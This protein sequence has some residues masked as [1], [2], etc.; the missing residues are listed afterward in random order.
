[1]AN[2]S[3]RLRAADSRMVTLLGVMLATTCLSNQVLAQSAPNGSNKAAPAE[4][5]DII[6]TAQRRETELTD[7]PIA[8]SAIGAEEIARRHIVDLNDLQLSVP[9]LVFVQ[10]TRQEAFI[11]I[12]GTSV[13]NDKP[14]SDPGVSVFVDGV[15]RTGVH[16]NNPDLFDLQ[17]AE[18]LRGPQGTLFGRNTTG[19]A[20]LLRTTDPSF[21]PEV[22]AQLTYGSDNLVDANALVTG[23]VVGDTLAGKVAF[24]YHRR[25]PNVY[26]VTQARYN[27]AEK[28]YSVRG[29]L[30][31]QPI[32]DLKILMRADYLRD[33]SESRVGHLEGTFAPVLFPGLQFGPDITN[34]LFT[35]HAT[36]TIL[37]L[38]ATVDWALDAG[39]ITSI[40]GYRAVTPNIDYTPTGDPFAE[41]LGAQRIRDHQL[42]Q[43][44]HFASKAGGRLTYL[45]GLFYLHLNRADDTLFTL[46]ALPGTALSYTPG[47]TPGFQ[48]HPNEEVLT[49]SR[50]AFGELTY[51]LLSDL[52]FTLGARYS[53]ESRSGHTENE[54]FASSGPYSHTWN[55]FTPK[56][57]ISFRPASHVLIY[58]TV[59]KGFQSGGFDAAA[60]TPGGLR[61]PFSPETV[62]NYELGLKIKAF[63]NRL[64]GNLALFWA[65]Y[66]NLQRTEFDSDPMV[67]AYKTTN[68]GKARVKGVELDIRYKPL[69]WLELG[70]SYAYTD[71][72][73]RAYLLLQDDGSFIDYS[74]NTVPQ[75]PK[76]QVHL[77][78]ELN[79]PLRSTGGML[80]FGADYT[81]RS[82]IQFVDANDTPTSILD[83][84]QYNGVINIHAGWQAVSGR[85]S[86][87]LFAKNVT[88][89][90]A[91]V[92]FPDFTPYFANLPEFRNP[93]NHIF[94]SRY[95]PIKTF[96]VTLTVKE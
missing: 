7:T 71:A 65:D 77:S 64:S 35:P 50:A 5:E 61:T 94:F 24:S 31:W 66:T 59:A 12:R 57:T 80:N 2:F 9:N 37:G 19:G 55:S 60:Q 93:A 46:N 62:I 8:I 27:G 91:L 81:Y 39:T 32:S 36:N 33:S 34:A 3:A 41:V 48:T 87:S 30:L 44:L 21:K 95:S 75:T 92:S 6:V 16:D 22:R 38:S 63:E 11:S 15:P 28:S 18:I 67:N 29:A 85:F 88:N 25:D 70:G 89:D 47:L 1:M 23:P 14:G 43:E 96:G 54:P 51:K 10:V 83:K 13:D 90:R 73:Y 4:I 42:S 20:V 52:D 74:G 58:A 79:A 53:S 17:S 78:A 86:I 49:Q 26:N 82:Q 68:A 69:P 72:K 84:S 76:H 56:A 45:L 40:T